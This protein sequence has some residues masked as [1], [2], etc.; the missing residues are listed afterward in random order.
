MAEV[1]K[2]LSLLKQE[3]DENKEDIIFYEAQKV[4]IRS[5]LLTFEETPDN[6]AS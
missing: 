5:Q 2:M 6:S 1:I 4:C 3:P